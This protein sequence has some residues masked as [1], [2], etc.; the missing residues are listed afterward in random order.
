MR[1]SAM[2]RATFSSLKGHRSSMEPPPRPTSS[3]CDWPCRFRRRMDFT[4][5]S[6]ARSPCTEQGATTMPTPG[7]RRLATRMMSRTAAPV[8]EVATPM[9]VGRKGNSRF[10]AGS[11]RPSAMSFRFR[12]S[13]C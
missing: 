12:A 1:D 2:A 13:N 6:A 7:S 4:I 9:T 10:R 5:S 3:T 11:N 8:L